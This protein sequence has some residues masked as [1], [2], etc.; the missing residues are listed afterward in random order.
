MAEAKRLLLA[1]E[2][3]HLIQTLNALPKDQFD[4]LVF[5]LQPPS[6]NIPSNAAS[7]GTRST[8]LLQWVESPIGPG[9][10]DLEAVLASL[11]DSQSP[12]A[13]QSPAQLQT[14]EALLTII[15]TL[16]QNQVPKYDLRGA[17][18]VGG[19]AETVQGNQTGGTFNNYSI[20]ATGSEKQSTCKA[21]ELAQQVDVWFRASGYGR[22]SYVS[23]EG[24]YCEW[25]ITIPGLRSYNRVLVRC[26]AG[27]AGMA[28]FRDLEST[29]ERLRPHEGWL[30]SNRR[31]STAVIELL[32]EYRGSQKLYCYTLDEVIDQ[33]ANFEIYMTKLEDEILQ[34]GI[35]KYYIPLGCSKDEIDPKT[36]QKIGISHYGEYEG[37]I[38][39]YVDRWLADPSKEHLSIQGEFGTGKTWFALH[40]AW[41]ALQKYRKAKER[42]LERPRLPIV[43]PL[44]DYSK[45]MSVEALFSEFFFRTHEISLPSYSAF[46]QLNR[47][48][49]LL[50]IFDG[51]DEMAARV[52]PEVMI[53]NFWELA[54]VIVPGAKAILTCRTEH[55]PDA[56]NGRRLLSAEIKV[57]TANLTGEAPQFEVLELE[58]FNKNQVR[59]LLLK[60]QAQPAVIQTIMDDPQLLDLACRPVM[61]DLILEALPEIETDKSVN[62]S[63]IYLYA[64]THK[65]KRDI[66]SHRTF[67]LFGR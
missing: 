26:V 45:V 49:K 19:F 41:Q 22:E 9:L 43:I 31:I 61:V 39:G 14:V 18:F 17:Q 15:Q 29:V 59:E 11:V 25:I 36:Q 5:A 58:K 4:Q 7:Q 38:E 65:M 42:G 21:S 40:Y 32:H 13:E 54:K 30:I 1:E 34:K 56:I 62:M 48:G 12:V 57:S 47:M 44:R 67:Y 3:L 20:S 27:E 6:G 28:D 37:W 8:A 33:N 64:V 51:F 16:S 55:F 52:N 10:A 53:N 60:R 24:K 46:E 35:D 63:Q 50:L 66:S 2:R 23:I